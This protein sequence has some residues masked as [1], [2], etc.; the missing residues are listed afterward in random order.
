MCSASVAPLAMACTEGDVDHFL[1]GCE[2]GSVYSG[3]RKGLSE[4]GS[5][6]VGTGHK[7]GGRLGAPW[8]SHQAPVT[9]VHVHPASEGAKSDFSY[10]A[11][12]SSM[13]YTCRLW[14]RKTGRCVSVHGPSPGTKLN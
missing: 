6:G 9:A 12:S 1:V 2:D 13:D 4:G 7:T 8:L 3:S 11:A 14:D 5:G 10:L